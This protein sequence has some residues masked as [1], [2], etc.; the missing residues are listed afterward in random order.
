MAGQKNK[1]LLGLIVVAI[2]MTFTAEIILAQSN[3]ITLEEA[4]FQDSDDAQSNDRQEAEY[5]DYVTRLYREILKRDPD[6]EG[7]RTWV[8]G[9]KSGEHTKVSVRAG[10]ENSV[11]KQV[12]DLYREILK[13]DPDQAGVETWMEAIRAGEHTLES[14]KQAILKS[15]E[16]IEKN[17]PPEAGAPEAPEVGPGGL[18]KVDVPLQ[19]QMNVNCPA[20]QSACGPTSLAMM[21]AH[22]TGKNP[23]ELAS[24]LYNTCGTDA[25]VGTAHA[26]LIR[27][28]ASHGFPNARWQSGVGPSWLRE[29]LK[30][31]KPV[32]ANVYNHYVVVTGIDDAG[33]IY[34]NDP[35]NG[36]AEM[37]SY[38]SFS[39]WWNGGGMSHAAMVLH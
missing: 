25:A 38:G 4:L 12:G 21:L 3:Q 14:V 33:N 6:P 19:C 29:Q 35:A 39:A 30:S 13:R 23:S 36:R 26:G 1:E 9:L 31:G 5:I 34:Y 18:I 22:Y 27:G 32:I 37:R 8:G 16:S 20:P 17:G 28:A 24:S 11:E 7:L 10:I 15:E 2:L